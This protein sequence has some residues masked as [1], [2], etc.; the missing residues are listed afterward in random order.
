VYGHV[1]RIEAS[2][3]PVVHLIVPRPADQSALLGQLT[4]QSR[5]FH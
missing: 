5:V 3:M 4:A 2:A 1:E